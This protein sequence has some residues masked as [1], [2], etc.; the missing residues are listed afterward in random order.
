MR[1]I[2]GRV[3]FGTALVLIAVLSVTIVI[4]V[5]LRTRPA[6]I[7]GR[8][9]RAIGSELHLEAA[10]GGLSVR[11]RPHASLVATDVELRSPGRSDVPPFVAI[12]RL[13][14]EANPFR[15]AS[16]ILRGHVHGV[17]VEGLRITIPP[18]QPSDRPSPSLLKAVSGRK[19]VIIDDFVAEHATL[20]ILHRDPAHRPLVFRIH[21]LEMRDLAFDRPMPFRA[22]LTNP[23]PDGEVHSEGSVGPWQSSPSDLPLQGHYTFHNA[24]LDT[25]AGIGGMLTSDGAYT[26][27][28]GSL[29]V[30]G[31]TNTPNFNLDMGGRAVPLA[32]TFIAVVNGSNGT[33]H[34]ESVDA[35]LFGTTVHVTGDIVNLP[36]P[37]GFDIALAANVSHGRIED[38]LPLVMDAAKPPMTGDV[39]VTSSVQLPAGPKPVRDRLTIDARFAL[40]TARFTDGDIETKIEKLSWRGRGKDADVPMTRVATNL[41]G[42]LRLAGSHV[43][44]PS[45]AFEVPGA[46]VMLQGTYGVHD[47]AMAFQGQLRTQASLSNVVGGFK[48]LFIKPFDW[49]FRRDGAGAVIPIRIEGTRDH[50]QFGVRIGAALTRGR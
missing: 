15:L 24:D 11:F 36:G 17:H 25:I 42:R 43:T 35:R 28:L 27:T 34:L 18:S 50:P 44:F 10:I 46:T 38:I 9:A 19:G 8:V 20:T 5:F 12:D 45:L 3:L 30:E 22:D 48:S 41:N 4:A 16:E 7:R 13:S 31:R 47:S 23:I 14:V 21:E 29:R 1:R 37:T 26:G 32:T 49:L 40:T 2:G 39:S 6:Y 33:T